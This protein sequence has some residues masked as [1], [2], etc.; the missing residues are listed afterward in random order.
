MSTK[1]CKDCYYFNVCI[2]KD[3]CENTYYNTC[4]D[5]HPVTEEAENA[6]IDEM[7]EQERIEYRSAWFEYINENRD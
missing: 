2:I 5:F 1:E 6:M 4:D 3:I 7:I